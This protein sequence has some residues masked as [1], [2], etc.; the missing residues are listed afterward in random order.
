[1]IRILYQQNSA[2]FQNTLSTGFKRIQYCTSCLPS[3]RAT[4]KRKKEKNADSRMDLR[5]CHNNKLRSGIITRFHMSRFNMAEFLEISMRH[6]APKQVCFIVACLV[7]DLCPAPL[8]IGLVGCHVSR[9]IIWKY[10]K[11]VSKH[12]LAT[13]VARAASKNASIIPGN[14]P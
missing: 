6:D 2:H 7:S 5:C 1:M 10:C 9:C 13:E 8:F 11:P 4:E 12:Q 3:F 14:Y